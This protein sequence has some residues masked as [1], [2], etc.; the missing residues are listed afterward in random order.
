M[1]ILKTVKGLFGSKEKQEFPSGTDWERQTL[2]QLAFAGLIEQR[3]ARRWN[4]FFKLFFVGYLLLILLMANMSPVGDRAPTGKF[5][6]IIDLNGVIAQGKPASADNLVGALRDAFDSKAKAI[7]IRAN[8]GGGSAVQSAYVRDEIMRLRKKH[9]DKKVYAVVSDMCASGCYYIIS[10]ADKIYANHSSMIGSIGVIM[11]SFGFTE[12]MKK[13]G[14]E[15]RV[16]TAGENKAMLDPFQP[17]KPK[18]QQN[19]KEILRTIHEEFIRVV[20]EG[21]G[22]ALKPTPDMFSGRIWDANAAHK[23]GLIDEFGS[24]SFVAREVVGADKLV[25]FT[26]REHWLNRFAGS[27]GASI[28]NAIAGVMSEQGMTSV[29]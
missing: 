24:S 16:F 13:L 11:G 7:V 28:G 5:T 12:A 4:L 29:R 2:Q 27:L 22:D 18:D 14:I 10:A 20:R 17:L 8:S 23:I 25:D 9:E 21:R 6:A 26:R 1:D 19:I 3:K 15:R